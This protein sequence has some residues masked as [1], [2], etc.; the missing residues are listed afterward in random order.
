[1]VQQSIGFDGIRRGE[2][3]EA[4][5]L[6]NISSSAVKKRDKEK[7]DRVSR[8]LAISILRVGL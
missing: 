8:S 3:E 1:M 4:G 5:G 6:A 2:A 7:I